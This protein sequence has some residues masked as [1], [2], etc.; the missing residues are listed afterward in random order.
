MWNHNRKKVSINDLKKGE[1]AVITKCDNRRLL[2]HGF[3]PGTHILIY[4]K[5]P[6]MTCV[7]IRGTVLVCRKTDCAKVEVKKM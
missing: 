3:T 2:E 1:T 4:S 5:I 7:G 6:F